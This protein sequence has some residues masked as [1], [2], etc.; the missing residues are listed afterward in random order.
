MKQKNK[1]KKVDLSTDKAIQR[2]FGKVIS[3]GTELLET[4]KT[5]KSLTVSPKLD[6]ALNGGLLEGSWTIV[7]GDPKTGKSTT[8]LQI[9]KN[10]QDEERPVIY[11]DGE[12]RL[13][14]YNLL[15]IDN[16]DLEKIQIV[17]SPE[18]GEVLAAEDFLSIAEELIKRPENKGAVCVIDSCSSLIPRAELEESASASI[19]ASL[20]K[21]LSHWI[22]KNAQTV[23]KN[24]ILVVIITHYITNTS[25][26]GKIKVPDCG[27][28]VQYQADTRMDIHRIQSWDDSNDKK[29]GQLVEW[30]ISSSSMGASGTE[31]TSFIRYGKGIDKE[32]EMID[33]AESFGVIDKSGAWYSIPFLE[34]SK[35][36]KD[37]PKFHG[38]GKIYDFLV[39]RQ[40]ILDQIKTHVN[41]MLADV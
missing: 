16:L 22:K 5:L 40:D 1:K 26:Y 12:S 18:D 35:E 15:G 23:T 14:T 2:A 34:N 41:T 39:E 7:S 8:C 24:R 28:M 29:I 25:G 37:A 19:R 13:K 4:K 36:F 30:R 20:P 21:L 9:C 6:L 10:A 11:V 32:Q 31:C 3:K 27:V 17:H 33:L 38:Q